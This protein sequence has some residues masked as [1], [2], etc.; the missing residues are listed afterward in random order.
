MVSSISR[1]WVGGLS[2]GLDTQSLIEQLI[3]AESYTKLSL[4]RKR[5]TMTYQRDMLQGVNLKLFEL[6]NKATDLTFSRTFNSK[7]VD[8]SDSRVVNAKA[9][10]SAAIGSYTVRVK[11]I[12]TSSSVSSKAKLA[13]S[14]ELGHNLTSTR[15]VGGSSTTL[16]ALGISAGDLEMNIL[17]G[18]AG[19]FNISTAATGSTTLGELITNINTSINNKSELK[20]KVNASYDEKN[21]RIK[22]NLL[23]QK[24]KISVS[25]TGSSSI[26]SSMFEADGEVSLNKDIPAVSSDLITIRSGLS[27]TIEDLGISTGTFSIQRDAGGPVETFDISALAPETTVGQLISHLNGE[28]DSRNTLAKDG[29]ATGNPA[30]RLLEF[31]YDQSSGK[32]QLVNTNSGDTTQF[33]LADDSSNLVAT[34]FGASSKTSVT[35]KGEKLAKETFAGTISSGVF[36][37]DGVQININAQNDDLQGVLSRITS[38]TDI[39]ATY[40]SKNDVIRLTRKNNSNDPIGLGS[41]TDSSNFLSIAGLIAGSQASAANLSSSSSLG[42]TLA[43]AKD[44]DLTTEFGVGAGSL[45]IIVNGKTSEISYDGSD[46]LTGVLEKIAAVDGVD[47]AFYDAS[48]GKVTITT[49]VR[50]SSATLEIQDVGAS[51]LGA[52]LGL[53]DG[54]AEGLDVGSS[55]VSSRPVS[56]L[57]TSAS[58]ETAGFATPVAAGTFTINGVKFSINNT[59]SLTMDSLINTINSNSEVGVKAHYDLTNGQF[60]LTSTETGN[61]AIALGSASDTSNFLSAMG[62]VGATQ[63]VGKNAIYSIDGIYGGFDQ[64]SQTNTVSDAIEGV[65]LELYD[66]TGAA[67]SVINI[68]ADTETASTAIKDFLTAY[69]E[70]TELVYSHLTEERDWELTALSDEERSALGD[71]DLASYEAAY[72]KGLLAGD[73]TLRTVRSQMRVIMSS[74]VPGADS[75]FNSLSDIGITTGTIGSSYEDTMLGTLQVTNQTKLDGALRDNPG[76]VAELFNKEGVG[77]NDKGIA[78]SLKDA[79]NEFTKSD[80]LLTKRVGKSG[81]A[82]ANS[83]MDKQ[84]A[85]INKQ[86]SSQEERLQAREEA[87]LKQFST[88]ETAMSEY[89]SQSTAFSNQLAQLA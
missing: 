21:N 13:G 7:T 78:R 39:N 57:K 61:R 10:T 46:S 34:V 76:K 16:D 80:G 51:T 55:V 86:I 1:N 22:I 11:Q 47:Q 24:L 36:T 5:N 8:A 53:T 48:T 26:I 33:T 35:D 81:V 75:L 28:I 2:S 14:L 41:S 82:S 6:Q 4:E 79:L 30:D 25:D 56:D 60:V 65:T 31:R 49:D 44:S 40:D 23:D 17:S 68:E 54:V 20:G 3:K 27:A 19:T 77:S 15:P 70:V 42:K 63:N 12:A 88:L 84:I 52:A 32:L 43:E 9:T 66:V 38:M 72:Q 89:Q 62:L 29:V 58:L 74:I 37:V 83:E 69:N 85:L 50:G 64:V 73:S 67:G 45:K 71:A 87:L 18:G 59:S